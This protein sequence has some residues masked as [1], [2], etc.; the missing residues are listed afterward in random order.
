MAIS[1]F[2]EEEKKTSDNFMDAWR[3]SPETCEQWLGVQKTF[4][5]YIDAY[6]I[7]S[8]KGATS[9]LNKNLYGLGIRAREM[10]KEWHFFNTLDETGELIKGRTVAKPLPPLNFAKLRL[11]HYKT[12]YPTSTVTEGSIPVIDDSEVENRTLTID[13][14]VEYLHSDRSAYLASMLTPHAKVIVTVRDPLDRAL[15]QYNMLKRVRN[16]QLR[17][18]GE[19]DSPSTAKEFHEKIEAEMK[20]LVECG[21]DPESGTY[22]GRTSTLVGCLFAARSSTLPDD[23]L[24][25]TRGLYHLH[26]KA[27]RDHFPA[28][29]IQVVSFNDVMAGKSSV[30]ENLSSFLCMREFP[31]KMLEEFEENGTTLSFGQMAAKEGVNRGT[32]DS[33]DGNDRYLAEMMPETR[34]MMLSFYEKADEHLETLLG[35]RLY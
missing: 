23:M 7:G 16:K 22:E 4:S 30:Y 27:W 21:F 11:Q 25:V 26:L 13:S 17:G 20:Q 9:Q 33:Y 34:E 15:S 18:A 10:R 14:T 28:H 35:R 1:R 8:Q 24:Y 19:P 31:R 12:G 32:F 5:S 3:H 6:I 2:S 29:R